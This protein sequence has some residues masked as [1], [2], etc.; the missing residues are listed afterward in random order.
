MINDKLLD[1][2]INLVN[3]SGGVLII[4]KGTKA[5]L[6]QN[7]PVGNLFIDIEMRNIYQ[8]DGHFWKS[9]LSSSSMIDS[10]ESNKVIKASKPK[11]ISPI[12]RA[13]SPF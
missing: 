2:L 1:I 12:V 13:K 10:S 5:N 8:F 6:P 11:D 3:D 7:Q 9:L 4:Q